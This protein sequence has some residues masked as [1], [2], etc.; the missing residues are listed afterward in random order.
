MD[1]KLLQKKILSNENV[2]ITEYDHIQVCPDCKEIYSF[3]KSISQ[4]LKENLHYPEFSF[5]IPEL[6]YKQIRKEKYETIFKP[7][8]SY[9]FILVAGLLL[10]YFI[11]NITNHITNFHQSSPPS[12]DHISKMVKINPLTPIATN[13]L[14]NNVNNK[15]LFA[16]PLEEGL[17]KQLNLYGGVVIRK[18]DGIKKI[19]DRCK[20][21][22]NNLSIDLS[23]KDNDI[24]IEVNGI[25]IKSQENLEKEVAKSC[26]KIT[27]K[28]MRNGNVIEKK[29]TIK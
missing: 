25:P 7:A 16:I 21:T 27:L 18:I 28:I 23:V 2:S 19:I 17:K 22:S 8:F 13:G 4:N 14:A 6:L 1:C 24:I 10:G 9:A 5:T 20:K 3:N 29:I 11:G 26:D 15:E 12:S